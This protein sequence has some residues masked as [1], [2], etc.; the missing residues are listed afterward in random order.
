[1]QGDRT[2]VQARST[3]TIPF[4]WRIVL[5]LMLTFLPIA[6][7]SNASTQIANTERFELIQPY[8]RSHEERLVDLT[9]RIYDEQWPNRARCIE[10]GTSR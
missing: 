2:P 3:C 9:E 8:L 4:L 10:L 6:A 7:S 5:T 1:M